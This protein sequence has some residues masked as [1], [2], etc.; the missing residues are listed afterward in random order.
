M[1]KH[2]YEL[3]YRIPDDDYIVGIGYFTSL[4]EVREYITTVKDDPELFTCFRHPLNPK[5][6]YDPV[7]VQIFRK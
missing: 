7:Q 6:P 1:K 5:E 2:L 3:D 4:R